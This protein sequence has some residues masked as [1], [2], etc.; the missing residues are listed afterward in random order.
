PLIIPPQAT[1][2]DPL[3]T[4]R[5]QEGSAALA[6]RGSAAPAPLAAP[7]GRY[8]GGGRSPR[9]LRSAPPRPAGHPRGKDAQPVADRTPLR[10]VTREL[11]SYQLCCL[12]VVNEH[13]RL[14]G[15]VTVDDVLGHARPDAWRTMDGP[16]PD[17]VPPGRKEA[18]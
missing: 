7:P 15:A 9:R 6:S 11:A 13:H 5:E 10:T 3:A 16:E 2:A 8:L 18:S 1:V 14:V 4:I 12:P 17:E